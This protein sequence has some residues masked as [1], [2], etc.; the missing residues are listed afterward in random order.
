[1]VRRYA[2][3]TAAGAAMVISLTGC[4]GDSGSGRTDA[5][6]VSA[7]QAIGLASK[8]TSTVDSYKVDLTVDGTGKASGAAHAVIQV[9]LRPDLAAI[10]NVDQIKVGGSS[11]PAGERAILL[12]DNLYAKVPSELSRFTGGKPWVRFSVSQAARRAGVNLNDLLKRADPAE[13]TKIFTGSKDVHRVGTETVDGVQTTHYQGSLTPKEAAEK[14]DSK[15]RRSFQDLYQ[16]DGAKQIVFDLWVGADNLPRKLTS[17]VTTAKASASSTMV[18]SGYGRS[19]TV[20][21]PPANQVA[22]GD[23]LAGTWDRHGATPGISFSG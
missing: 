4:L 3:S 8:K 22:D 13:Q 9:R 21:A 18:Y 14:L 1:M 16:R 19:F 2:A 12:G 20:S 23:R 6:N 15:A 7:A 17:K 11:A 5:V 10:G